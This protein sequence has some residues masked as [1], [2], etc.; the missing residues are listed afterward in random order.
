M[1]QR[2]D[3][4]RPASVAAMVLLGA[5]AVAGF[6]IQPMYLGALADHLGF[7]AE[8]LGLIAGLEV[9]GSALAGIAATFWIRRWHWQRVALAALLA[10][11]A[12]N[13]LSAIVT[14]FETLAAI[15]FLTGFLGIGSS[16]ALAIA[17]LSNTRQTE[18]N[19]SIA[20][21]AQVSA[22]IAGFIIL[23]AY[24]GELGTPAVFLPLAAIAVLVLPLL[25]NLPVSG[26]NAGPD[27]NETA[28]SAR[29]PIWFALACQCVW[30]L[31]LGGVWAFME[32]MG[33]DAGID[34]DS[35][36]KALAIGMVVGLLGAFFAAAV[37]DRFG[38]VIPFILAMLGQV[39][40]VW[41]LAG[42]EDLNGLVIAVSIYN[43]TWNFALPY[44]FSMATL[45]DT[46]GQLVVLMSTAQA[47]GLTFGTT[48]A[49]VV[50]GR[51]GLAAVTWQGGATAIAALLIFIV[52]GQV[53]SGI[54][55]SS[56]EGS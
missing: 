32:R 50:I 4:D 34:T 55:A 33:A 10:L 9:A 29:W 52:L 39:V 7:S 6:N 20:I 53:L 16:Y 46:R 49:G 18:R 40:A 15:R 2:V 14:H 24:I 54:R 56:A 38:R 51:W 23:P 17:A 43:G 26:K 31:G 8:Q 13:I 19:Y 30:Y 42:L 47:V 36:G 21:V 45:A 41:M 35:I 48:L 25:K 11:A 12:G 1:N 44:L 28:T 3:T 5:V 27:V 22:A 37:A